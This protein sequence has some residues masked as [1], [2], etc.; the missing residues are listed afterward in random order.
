M[1]RVSDVTVV[2]GWVEHLAGLDRDVSDA[3]RIE[4]IRGLEGLKASA[5]AAQARLSSDFD[6]SQR[7]AQEA[8]GV[9]A[10]RVGRGI[11]EQ[12][13]L[14]RR[15]S[16]HRGGRHLGVGKALT[17]EMPHTLEALTLGPDQ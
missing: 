16:P 17:R 9:P 14:A 6:V 4:L 12:V 3:E 7:E 10:S 15:D 1:D 2:G 5:A 13:A 11:G 8:A